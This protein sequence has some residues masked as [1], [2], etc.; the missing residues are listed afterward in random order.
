MDEI[1]K[2]PH[3]EF[4][5][6][7]VDVTLPYE[8]HLIKIKTSIC[9]NHKRTLKCIWEAGAFV[10][11]LKESEVYGDKQ[12]TIENFIEDMADM[13]VSKSEVYK[14]AKFSEMYSPAQV[15]ELLAVPKIGWGVVTN[16][17]R[18]KD[19]DTRRALEEQVQSGELA[20]S[21]VPEV[22]SALNN[23][24][25]EERCGPTCTKGFSKLNKALQNA[26]GV[27]EQCL[28]DIQDLSAIL[29]DEKKYE[30][31]VDLME[32]FLALSQDLS[33]A[34][35]EIRTVLDKTI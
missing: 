19:D 28:K 35:T 9:N 17:L 29:N 1:Q 32:T 12:K 3:G 30:K 33:I 18:V 13:K 24:Q 2:I 7:A 11:L 4:I 15:N 22:V 8:E 27:R 5:V 20:V 25:K 10:N 16:L 34:L 21:K 14:W 6:T 23:K 31:A 26:L